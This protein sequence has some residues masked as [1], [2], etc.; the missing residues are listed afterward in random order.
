MRFV[1]DVTLQHLCRVVTDDAVHY[2]YPVSDGT[3]LYLVEETYSPAKEQD[4]RL[5]FLAY[6]REVLPNQLQRCTA[7]LDEN[8][9][10][11]YE[12]DTVKFEAVYLGSVHEGI[13]VWQQDGFYIKYKGHDDEVH[14]TPLSSVRHIWKQIS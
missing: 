13:I 11:L 1:N 8:Q 12:G 2:G 5:S 10:M 3:R 14:L 7:Y 4:G 9:V 6:G